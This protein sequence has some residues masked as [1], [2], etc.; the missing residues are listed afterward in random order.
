MRHNQIYRVYPDRATYYKKNTHAAP[1]RAFVVR[2]SAGTLLCS[3][4]G[5]GGAGRARLAG[6]RA[7]LCARAL[8]FGDG[9]CV[10]VCVCGA[11]PRSISDAR[12]TARR[13]TDDA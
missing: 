11:V 5:T 4:L 12:H 7:W 9:A 2:V 1:R 8:I 13:R 6:H 3:L 10:Y